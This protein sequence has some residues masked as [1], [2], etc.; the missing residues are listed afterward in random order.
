M[1][2][3]VTGETAIF[4]LP[5]DGLVFNKEYKIQF[6]VRVGRDVSGHLAIPVAF[7]GP[8]MSLDKPVF[9]EVK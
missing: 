4:T 7:A 2:E 6:K 1:T 5:E 8:G 3:T 9:V